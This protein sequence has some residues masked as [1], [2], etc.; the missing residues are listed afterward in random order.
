MKLGKKLLSL[1]T[2]LCLTLSLFPT[3]ALAGGGEASTGTPANSVTVGNVI[4]NRDEYLLNGAISKTQEAP[5]S[6]TGYIHFTSD[7]TLEL[8]GYTDENT[9]TKHQ[10]S[11]ANLTIHL[12]GNNHINS[13]GNGIYSAG[14]LTISGPGSLTLT[15]STNGTTIYATNTI[16]IQGGAQV[17]AP[18][19]NNGQSIHLNADEKE[20][21]ITG[22]G[23]V[24]N[25]IDSY[26][27][28][29]I[30]CGS[31]SNRQ[32]NGNIR[33]NNGA[34]LNA[35]TIQGTLL[36]DGESG[37]LNNNTAES[38]AKY[39]VSGTVKNGDTPVAGA[40]V[41]LRATDTSAGTEVI[42][43]STTNSDGEYRLTGISE[44][45]YTIK[46]NKSGYTEV[47]EDVALQGNDKTL[48]KDITLTPINYN[49]SVQG[50]PVTGANKDNVLGDGTVTYTPATTT[51][52]QKLTLNGMS[53]TNTSQIGITASNDLTIALSGEN[54]ISSSAHAIEMTNGTLTIT[55]P[56]SLNASS[57]SGQTTIYAGGNV[58]INSGAKITAI[59]TSTS[60]GDA[61]HL[62]DTTNK[63]LTIT[64]N[65]TQVIAQK[66]G[67]ATAIN[68]VATLTVSDGATLTAQSNGKAI[69]CSTFS[70]DSTSKV[71]VADNYRG[72]TPSDYSN[73]TV[74]SNCKY[75]HVY[76]KT[77]SVKHYGVWIGSTELTS[78]N[79]TSI[80]G[81]SY[82]PTTQTLT[83]NGA[84]ITGAPNRQYTSTIKDACGIY[85]KHDL[86]IK[87]SG[88]NTVIGSE[89][90][91]EQEY[92]NYGIFVSGRLT[93]T[94]ASGSVGSLTV[95]GGK[96]NN[97]GNAWVPGVYA[98]GI[99]V[100]NCNVTVSGGT[101]EHDTYP[102]SYAMSTAP[103]LV[104]V[105]ATASRNRDGSDAETYSSSNN[106][107]YKWI[108]IEQDATNTT[109]ASP[110]IEPDSCYFTNN[111]TVTISCLT[112]GA[113]IYYST[114]GTNFSEYRNAI[115][116]N[117]TTTITAYATKD[118]KTSATITATFTKRDASAT[119]VTSVILDKSELDLKTN[120][121]ENLVATVTPANA[122]DATVVWTSNDPS[123]ATIDAR[124]NVTTVGIGKARITATTKD[125]G[126]IAF[127]DVIV[128]EREPVQITFSDESGTVSPANTNAYGKLST[129]P[130]PT[131]SGY[132]FDG[133][134]TEAEGGTAVTTDTVF[135]KATTIY[136]HWTRNSSSGSHTTYYPVNT[137][138]KSEGG[139]VVVSQKS[140]SR[141]T[142]V[143]VT[144]TAASG[145]QVAQVS[146]VDKDGKTVSL[147]DKGDGVYTFVMPAS[148]VDV[149]ARFA[150]VQ[151]PEEKDPYGDVSKDSYYY[152]AVK[153]AAETGVTTGVGDG[154]FAPEWVCTRGQIVTFL[155]RASGS[156]A[157]KATE[158]PFTD[159]AADA[160]Y[161]Q[162]VLWAVENGITNGTSETTFSP[163]QTCTRAHAVAFLYRMSGSPA[164]AGSTFSDVAADAYY[165]AAVAWAVEKG[166]TNGTSGTT[167]SPDDTCTRGQIVT[168]L[169]RLAQTK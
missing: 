128:T 28:G 167:F 27:T 139:S 157:P 33:V 49:I 156:P 6:G 32:Y 36:I 86:T 107:N 140:A 76:P 104:G 43:T 9:N 102:V 141:G 5:P 161:A 162:A 31:N 50:T 91:D 80:S 61:I 64:G 35:T 99:T 8:N 14:T 88:S 112:N 23:T 98:S 58:I 72:T 41:Q 116:I 134:Y 155:W 25:A 108:K 57:S 60:N 29:I 37:Q 77:A 159:V 117:D 55:G 81:V 152:D 10:I 83:L 120:Q 94:S 101:A 67:S 109:I 169:Y 143:T 110:V 160:Y 131:R 46:V 75:V 73:S 164:A 12:T 97:S 90:A 15:P 68:G 66:S 137:P 38:T 145:Y 105:K 69:S 65:N 118:D 2:V 114:D 147:T 53:I 129:L 48:T 158:L 126:Y 71:E 92:G 84:N 74:L 136:A 87:L 144:A 4:L 62:Y 89:N 133:W 166:I 135:D 153:W 127:C 47:T 124:G 100:N 11:G 40:S 95:S 39:T 1:L 16:K 17:I 78:A 163:D 93:F 122:S 52:A 18:G 115:P 54:E 44:G 42:P 121:N 154:L 19:G 151:K 106:R 103:T 85:A 24:V 82:E 59:N 70:P 7:G 123:V 56:G 45:S 51:E 168:F 148:K 125:G 21:I 20:I 113:R 34:K 150:Q 132:S 130:T 3:M 13:A 30:R 26:T 138:A 119:P 149:T 146:A 142:T 96:S 22:T 63:N 165:R 111:V 79:T